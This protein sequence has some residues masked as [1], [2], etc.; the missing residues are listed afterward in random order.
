MTAAISLTACAVHA[1]RW[2]TAIDASARPIGIFILE[3][4]DLTSV[5]HHID[6]GLAEG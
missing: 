6:I 3:A 4:P 5:P 2:E 1:K